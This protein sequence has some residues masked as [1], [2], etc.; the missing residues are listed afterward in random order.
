MSTHTSI[1]G[2]LDGIQDAIGVTGA[3]VAQILQTT[4]ETVSRWRV[5]RASPRQKSLEHLLRLDWLAVELSELYDTQGARIWLYSN[6]PMLK[7]ERPVDLI[8]QGKEGAHQ[9]LAVI[10]QLKDSAF[11]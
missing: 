11:S 8:S 10:N 6:Q 7:G 9:V 5:G 2:K 4:P 1:A 3:E